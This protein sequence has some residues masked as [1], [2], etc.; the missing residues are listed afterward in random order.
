MVIIGIIVMF[1]RGIFGYLWNKR[2]KKNQ[3]RGENGDS[4]ENSEGRLID[5]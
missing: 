5:P 2:W 1:R 4:S 3:V